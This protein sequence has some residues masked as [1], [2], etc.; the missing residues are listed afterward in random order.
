M[1]ALNQSN[2]SKNNK[3][4][5]RINHPLKSKVYQQPTQVW[6]KAMKSKK[7]YLHKDKR[8]LHKIKPNNSHRSNH[9]WRSQKKGKYLQRNNW[10]IRNR[11]KWNSNQQRRDAH[12]QR[13]L[14]MDRSALAVGQVQVLT[15]VQVLEVDQAM[16]AVALPHF[17]VLKMNL[18][19]P[20][21]KRNKNGKHSNRSQIRTRNC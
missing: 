13:V 14:Q 15:L 12:P 4:N 8:K 1:K 18:Y 5:L 11:A 3:T 19:I 17:Q 9:Q 21:H 20:N 2:H 16:K 10:Q 7:I 6:I